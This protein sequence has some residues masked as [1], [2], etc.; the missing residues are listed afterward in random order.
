MLF[1]LLGIKMNLYIVSE[2]SIPLATKHLKAKRNPKGQLAT[3]HCWMKYQCFYSAV[4]MVTPDMEH[5][6]QVGGSSVNNTVF[7]LGSSSKCFCQD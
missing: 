7:G 3:N 4:A 6:D 2:R 5:E 1:A